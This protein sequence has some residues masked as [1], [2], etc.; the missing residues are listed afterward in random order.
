MP[1]QPMQRPNPQ[2]QAAQ[3]QMGHKLG[4]ALRQHLRKSGRT[5]PGRVNGPGKGQDDVVPA[6]LSQD[7]YIV[8]ADVTGMLGDGSS[9]AGGQE[10]DKM[11]TNIRAHKTS[12][13]SGFPPKAKSPL[14]Y[15]GSQ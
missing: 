5:P 6:K 13:G 1:Q 15:I 11:V 4:Q 10:L 2:A 3:F 12:K 7:E 14:A 9:K 8:P